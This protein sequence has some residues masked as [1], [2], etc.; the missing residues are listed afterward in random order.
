MS[1]A[2]TT[3]GIAAKASRPATASAA[4][5][6]TS[7]TIR[8]GGRARVGQPAG[9]PPELLLAG[10]VHPPRRLVEADEP[11]HPSILR[12]AR[13]HQRQ[14]QALA[15]AAGQVARV[16]FRGPLEPHRCEGLPARLAGQ[17]VGDPLTDQ[18][19]ARA[20]G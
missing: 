14:R 6:A 10:T 12:A 20:L 3:L 8:A 1:V 16:G 15:L 9:P 19:V 7:A 2:A 5:A 17:L 11:W 13:H 18:Q 4:S